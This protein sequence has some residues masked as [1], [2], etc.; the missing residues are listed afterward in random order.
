M[1]V[2]E[3]L[4]KYRTTKIIKL[5]NKNKLDSS[6]EDILMNSINC[7]REDIVLYLINTKEIDLDYIDDIGF[8]FL[9]SAV[10]IGNINIVELLI[11]KGVNVGKK[12]KCGKKLIT[13]IYY[14][15][16]LE[17]LKHLEKYI[18]E[19]EIKKSL[20][21]VVRS[22]VMSHD[23]KLLDYILNKYKINIKRIKYDIQN[24]K[25]N[26]LEITEEVLQSM[27]NREYRKRE[28]AFYITEL[29]PSKRYRKIEKRAYEILNKIEEENNEIEGYYRYLKNKFEVKK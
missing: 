11:Q 18:E 8:D 22:T 14:V 19:K 29:L 24:K 26:I 17:M 4:K 23:I 9:S 15:K 12:Y 28:M 27:R 20:E 10:C 13:V 16:D 6:L 2:V 3:V 21:S 1:E 25:Y 7:N 5:I